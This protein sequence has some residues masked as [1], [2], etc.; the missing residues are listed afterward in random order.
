MTDL[1]RMVNEIYEGDGIV[2]IRAEQ[3]GESMSL[4]GWDDLNRFGAIENNE[5]DLLFSIVRAGALH[6]TR[7]GATE[8]THTITTPLAPA[9]FSSRT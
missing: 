3:N 5:D 2:L 6:H 9:T 8:R 7:C 4:E 1:E